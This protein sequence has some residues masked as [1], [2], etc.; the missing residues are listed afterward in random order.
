VRLRRSAAPVALLAV[1]LVSGC[2]G[3]PDARDHS[4]PAVTGA[5]ADP[6]SD[7]ESTVAAVEHEVDRDSDVDG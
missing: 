4:G 7:V 5:S 3:A 1:L 6:L 2:D